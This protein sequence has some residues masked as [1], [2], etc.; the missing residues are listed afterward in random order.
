MSPEPTPIT[1][2]NIVG[3]SY[4][5]TT[6]LNLVLGSSYE[7]FSIGEM[8]HIAKL[9][10]PLC[11]FHGDDCDIWAQ[12]DLR[13]RENPFD[14][15]ARITGKRVFLVNNT[16]RFL[17][18]MR[19]AHVTV[20]N[21]GLWRDG[22]AILA[23]GLRKRP[24]ETVTHVARSWKRAIRKKQRHLDKQP[25]GSVMHMHY[26]TLVSDR[27]RYVREIC[28]FIGIAYDESMLEYW[29]Q[30]H[31]Y[32]GGGTALHAVAHHHGVP[33]LWYR[34]HENEV[35][36]APLADTKKESIIPSRE[37]YQKSDP[38]TFV[39]K[40]WLKELTDEQ[41]TQFDRVAGSVNESLGYPPAL[42]RESSVE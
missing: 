3:S 36:E 26:E 42:Q 17:K 41:L 24:E 39:D 22:R 4:S 13:S 8:D 29:L 18:A 23:S 31:H 9:K 19:P 34:T 6:W 10:R 5:G 25:T 20:R 15:L 40:R 28:Q 32:I 11:V 27:P 2:V 38:K 12:F 1:V 14:Q 35:V 21:L 16:R 7:A 37:F 30:P 33:S